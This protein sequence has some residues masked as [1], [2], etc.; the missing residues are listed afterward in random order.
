MQEV[1]C[2]VVVGE[3]WNVNDIIVCLLVLSRL[4]CTSGSVCGLPVGFRW[5][6]NI[7]WRMGVLEEQDD[8]LGVICPWPSFRS[9]GYIKCTLPSLAAK[10]RSPMNLEVQAIATLC[11]KDRGDTPPFWMCNCSSNVACG[12]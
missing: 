11:G 1:D 3:W 7:F 5:S 9:I 10:K 8:A 6:V 4:C 12:L 2:V